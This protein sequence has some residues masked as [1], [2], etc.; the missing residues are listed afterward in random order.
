[1]KSLLAL[2]AAS[3]LLGLATGQCSNKPETQGP[4]A[5][6]IDL[7]T[8]ARYFF[9]FD[10][11]CMMDGEEGEELWG[12]SLCGPIVLVDPA[13]RQAV[14]NRADA[15]GVLQRTEGVYAGELPASVGIANTAFDWDG[16]RWTMII[17]WSLSENHKRRMRLMAHESFHRVQP[18]LELMAFGDVNAHLD[19]ADGRFW[20]QMEWNALQQ[21]L[22]AGGTERQ[23]AVA[24]ALAF[25][26]ARRSAFDAAAKREI[27]L[28][29]FEGLAEYTGM[30]LARFTNEEVV[31]AVAAKRAQDSGF[32]RSFAYVSGP[33]YGYLLDESGV[34]WRSRM[35]PEADVGEVL[36]YALGLS[37]APAD[38]VD[39]RAMRYGAVEL[40]TTEVERE[41]QRQ[42][43]LNAWRASL[44]DG[45]VMIVDLSLATS[46]TFDP[47]KVYP[48][49]EGQTVYTTRELMAEWGRLTVEDGAI[50]EDE[51]ASRAYVSLSGG[52]DDHLSGDGWTLELNDGWTVAPAEREGDFIVRKP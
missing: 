9:E 42:E 12:V 36:A 17:W 44:I 14:G 15:G 23:R 40:R 48:Y 38:D 49:A 25:R 46:G 11:L 10:V 21:A 30:R 24:D 2:I 8:A 34:E 39:E 3:C 43:R 5:G 7:A 16:E 13:T 47:R 45:P 19:T 35:S 4:A 29:I 22:L 41:R 50:L 37:T 26:A 33:L 32:V 31:E 1:V 18:E 27:P 51:V 28:E 52:A 20:M 6:N